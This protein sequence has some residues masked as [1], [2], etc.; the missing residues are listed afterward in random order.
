MVAVTVRHRFKL[1]LIRTL[2]RFRVTQD[3]TISES[4]TFT[5]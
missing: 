3:K 1:A 2:F 4:S 5:V